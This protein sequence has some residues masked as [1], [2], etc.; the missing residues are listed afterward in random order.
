MAVGDSIT[1]GYSEQDGYR[2]YFYHR[3]VDQKKY[4]IDMV[5]SKD[6]WTATWDFD[7]GTYS[8][9]PANTGYSGYTIQSYQYNNQNR[10][11][12]FETISS[13]EKKD[14]IQ[15]TSPEI[16]LL[17]IGTNDIMDS[18]K[19]DEIQA[20]LQALVDEIYRQKSDV[21]LMIMSPLPID[22]PVS[23]WL[24]QDTMN[25]NI[26]TCMTAIKKI[27]DAEKAAGKKCEYLATNELF[28]KQ[29]DYT[30]YLNDY[31][32]PNRA[33]YTLMGNYL[34]DAV[35]SYL[36]TGSVNVDSST[37]TITAETNISGLPSD[38]TTNP[39]AYK[40][41]GTYSVTAAQ[42]WTLSI[43]NLEEGYAYYV[44]EVDQTGWTPNY[45][46]NGQLADNNQAIE[47]TNTKTVE[48]VS[49]S[50]EKQWRDASSATHGDIS[51][52]LYRRLEDGNWETEPVRTATLLSADSWKYTFAALM[53]TE[54]AFFAVTS[55]VVASTVA[56]SLFI[57]E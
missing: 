6:G 37:G 3:L 2:K 20:R 24:Q 7:D 25:T 55:P 9:D 34:A 19:M 10:I 33:G 48:K 43:P 44:K 4:S 16:V 54:P 17:M 51:V 42:N 32:H 57:D 56:I 46:H 49:V 38:F 53:V 28:T 21:T 29:T 14:I 45:A 18:Y 5:G 35:D 50:V 26:K 36:R 47:I 8:Y 12:I 41:V 39:S 1:D 13:G 30:A 52:K 23:G 31:C 11:G 15:T 27:V 40:L 22:A